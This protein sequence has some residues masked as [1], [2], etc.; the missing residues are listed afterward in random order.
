MRRGGDNE[1]IIL[2]GRE[3]TREEE[4]L[5]VGE[6]LKRMT[7]LIHHVTNGTCSNLEVKFHDF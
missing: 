2:D 6:K 5:E 4:I 1:T 7:F 3:L